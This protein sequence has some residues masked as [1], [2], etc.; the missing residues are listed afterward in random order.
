MV[1]TEL[2]RLPELASTE[3]SR[4]DALLDEA[5]VGHFALQADGHP[6][7]IPTAIARDGDHVLAHGSTGSR[8]MRV[9]ADGAPT[10]LAVTLLDGIEVARSAFES[11]MH[12]RSAVLFGQCEPIEDTDAKRCALDHITDAL[13]PGRVA[14]VR[15]PTKKELAATLVLRLPIDRWSLKVSDG[16]PEDPDSDV[17][18]SAWAGAVPIRLTYGEPVAAP[19]LRS[20]IEVPESVRA[21]ASG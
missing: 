2:T 14:E 9:L 17:A 11:S 18:G 10:A 20:G 8:W 15:A 19:D 7:V 13:L 3:R 4:L 16:W 12:Y 5:K 21:L 6:G 1:R